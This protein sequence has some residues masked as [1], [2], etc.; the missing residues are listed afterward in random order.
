L[1]TAAGE[2]RCRDIGFDAK[3]RERKMD[4]PVTWQ[5][6]LTVVGASAAAIA[7]VQAIKIVVPT[8]SSYS[9]R[10]LALVC[11]LVVVEAATFFV[12]GSFSLPAHV[13]GIVVGLQAGLAA[14]KSFEIV[15][16]GVN[17]LISDA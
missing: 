9:A 16:H 13:L 3:R 11:G 12:N 2:S 10:V 1:G 15:K 4:Q 5:A 7:V 14:S 8:M 6:M 17:H